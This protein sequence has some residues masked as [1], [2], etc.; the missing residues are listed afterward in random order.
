[1]NTSPQ[2]RRHFH[3][4]V[5]RHFQR[6]FRAALG[7]LLLA[8]CLLIVHAQSDTSKPSVGTVNVDFDKAVLNPEQWHLT[9]H[10][11]IASEDYDLTSADIKVL[12]TPGAKSGVSGLREAVAV[13][14][15][16]PGAQVVAHVRQPLQSAS[17]EIHSDRAVY[18]PDT[19]RPSGGLLKFTGHV[20]VITKAGFLAEPSVSTT[21]TATILLGVGTQY[22]LRPQVETGPGHTTLTPAQ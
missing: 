3:L 10:A 9:G 7:V 18:Q 14:G 22:M 21:D 16:V 19:S 11:K 2:C 5:G 6:R 8:F 4:T 13:G 12:F 17:Y 1:M 15:A 20:Q